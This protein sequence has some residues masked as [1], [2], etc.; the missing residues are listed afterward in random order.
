MHNFLC[1]NIPIFPLSILRLRTI[2]TFWCNGIDT[3][4]S[5]GI[6]NAWHIKKQ[7]KNQQYS[8]RF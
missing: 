3:V 1:Q 7:M 5:G 8:Q 6:Q 2:G 4:W